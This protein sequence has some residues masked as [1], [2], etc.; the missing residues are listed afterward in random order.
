MATYTIDEAVCSV[1]L[2]LRTPQPPHS[3]V[4]HRLSPQP[5]LDAADLLVDLIEQLQPGAALV[6]MYALKPN[7]IRRGRLEDLSQLAFNR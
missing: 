1:K 7:S 5:L 4:S 2:S 3:F 6:S